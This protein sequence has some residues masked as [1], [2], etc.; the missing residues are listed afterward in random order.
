[1]NTTVTAG[2]AVGSTEEQLTSLVGEIRRAIPELT[3]VMVASEDGLSLCH[4]VPDADSDRIAALAATALGV[5]KQVSERSSLG[6][7]QETVVRGEDGYL[8]VYAA[9]RSA[10]LAIT[11]PK[12]LNLA[13]VRIQARAASAQVGAILP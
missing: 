7:F 8:V 4:D 9:G 3:G 1:M 11:G 5:G 2:A 6:S 12:N 13:L 10:V